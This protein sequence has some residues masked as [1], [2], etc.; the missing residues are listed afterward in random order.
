[1]L[2]YEPGRTSHN[3][4][5]SG[6]GQE[7]S[8]IWT[9]DVNGRPTGSPSIADGIAYVVTT[10]RGEVGSAGTLYAIHADTGVQRWSRELPA[11]ATGVPTVAGGVVYVGLDGGQVVGYNESGGR[12]LSIPNAAGPESVISSIAVVDDVLYIAGE[13]PGGSQLAAYNETGSQLWGYTTPEHQAR[14]PA[15]GDGAAYLAVNRSLIALSATDGTQQWNRTLAGRTM[16]STPSVAGGTVYVTTV[17]DAGT[18][19]PGDENGTLYAL[20]AANGSIRWSMPIDPYVDSRSFSPFPNVTAT[21]IPAVAGDTVYVGGEHLYAFDAS[22]GTLVSNISAPASFAPGDMNAHALGVGNAD[23]STQQGSP[24]SASGVV[25]ATLSYPTVSELPDDVA[26]F[27]GGNRLWLYDGNWFGGHHPTVVNGTLFVSSNRRVYAL[28]GPT[29]IEEKNP[30]SAALSANRSRAVVGESVVEFD[31]GNSIDSDG[32]IVEYQWDFDG[33]RGV[34]MTTTGPTATHVYTQTGTFDARVTVVDND[35]LTDTATVTITVVS[36]TTTEP[37]SGWPQFHFNAANTGYN[38]T[39]RG[40]VGPVVERWNVSFHGAQ[41]NPVTVADG[42][43]YVVENERVQARHASNGTLVWSTSLDPPGSEERFD[44]T[45]AP[46]V[47]GG[48]VYVGAYHRNTTGESHDE[49]YVLDATTGARIWSHSAHVPNW[50]GFFSDGHE[51]GAPKVVDGRLFYVGEAGDTLYAV[52][53]TAGSAH[54]ELWNRTLAGSARAPVA[55]S[56]GSVYV[57][58]T[59]ELS[60]YD[61]ASGSQRWT[62]SPVDSNIEAAPTVVDDRLYVGGGGQIAA[63]YVTNGSRVWTAGGFVT[64]DWGSAA[65]AGDLVL[66][67]QTESS[68]TDRDPNVT[69]LYVKNGTEAWSFTTNGSVYGAPAVVGRSGVGVGRTAY[70]GTVNGTLHGIDVED[71]TERWNYTLPPGEDTVRNDTTGG[72]D[73]VSAPLPIF[74]A[75]AVTDETV[76]VRAGSNSVLTRAVYAITDAAPVQSA[77]GDLVANRTTAR[78]AFDTVRFSVTNLTGATPSAYQWEFGDGATDRTTH[79]DTDVDHVYSTAGTLTVKVTALDRFDRILFTDSVTVTV[80]PAGEGDL[81]VNPSFADVNVTRVNFTVTNVTSGIDAHTYAWDFDGDGGVDETTTDDNDTDHVYSRLLGSITPSVEVS[82]SQG[83]TLFTAEAS[84]TVGDRIP[85][86]VVA[87]APAE[88]TSGTDFTV[89]A[90]NSTDNHRI[91]EFTFETDQGLSVTNSDGVATLNFSSGSIHRVN[92]SAVDPS[93]NRNETNLTIVVSEPPDLTA[94]VTAP[95]DQNLNNGS[96]HANVTVENVGDITARNVDVTLNVGSGSLY[97][98]YRVR[99]KDFTRS[100]GD[101]APGENR[102]VGIDFTDWAGQHIRAGRPRVKLTAVADPSDAISEQNE[103]NNRAETVTRVSFSDIH[104]NVYVPRGITNESRTVT[105]FFRNHGG[106]RSDNHT[107]QIDFGDGSSNVTVDIPPLE[108]YGR[109]RV[110]LKHT[111]TIPGSYTAVVNVTDDAVERG[112]VDRDT[113]RTEDYSLSIRTFDVPAE[114]ERGESFNPVVRFSRN[115][116]RP[117]NATLE[118]PE[119]LEFVSGS[120]RAVTKRVDRFGRTVWWQIRAVNES[121]PDRHRLNVTVESSGVTDNATDATEVFPARIQLTNTTSVVVLNNASGS[122]VGE[123]RT[124]TTYDHAIEITGQ[125]GA[126]GRTLSGLEYLFRYPYG[127]IEQTTSPL[128]GALGTDQYYRTNPPPNDYDQER[129]NRNIA[130][131]VSRLSSD[132]DNGQHANGAWSM[133]GNTPSGHVFYTAYALFG[134]GSVANDPVQGVRPAVRTELD[135]VDFNATPLWLADAQADDGHIPN[136]KRY[137]RDDNAMTGFTLLALDVGGPYNATAEAAADRIRENATRYLV[138]SQHADG[139]WETRSTPNGISTAIAV[140]GLQT[141]LPHIDNAT[142]EARAQA[143][144]DEGT[145]W[146]LDQQRPN[147]SWPG[148]FT[149][150]S[151]S[152]QGQVSHTTAYALMALNETGIPNTNASIARGTTYLVGVYDE[153]GSWGYTR[154]S[155]VA[156]DALQRLGT[157]GTGATQTVTVQ[158][159]NATTPDVVTKTVR[160]DSSTPQRTVELTDAEE[161]RLRAATDGTVEITVIG[162]GVGTAVI[163]V[164][165]DQLIDKDEYEANTGGG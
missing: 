62:T 159:G 140:R 83:R 82:D 165:N 81:V 94:S 110:D 88:V 133:Y 157:G 13:G 90:S 99:S 86:T 26:A 105:V 15:V 89:D 126:E 49:V 149:D 103:T 35:G 152:S 6:P 18:D 34:D 87:S 16:G 12:V 118:L 71:G 80:E 107:A 85:P 119:G 20:Y 115:D 142:L 117:V 64:N 60:A 28:A 41:T 145:V 134:T 141:A 93:G 163:A 156:I 114:A 75:P 164:Q 65:I 7:P 138:N 58:T 29:G 36:P 54:S 111:Y 74:T 5:V 108:R 161:A 68:F 32:S 102:T 122:T 123:I 150:F 151:W 10:R 76:Y 91:E 127:C 51:V 63:H 143:S 160:L 8:E 40:P 135:Q 112:N 84:L 146:L 121:T 113:A 96:V 9:F 44:V 46:T 30:P 25:Y 70:V 95:A 1:M 128:L 33:D 48:R 155:A 77:S 136:D 129:V 66:V 17:D 130:G 31:A 92:V 100:I 131:G 67:T 39:G 73:R 50:G 98:R 153:D 11:G 109:H 42:L 55:V 43:L 148:P 124:E 144:I 24:S 2:G 116:G 137:F 101:L 21:T 97:W 147:G 132:G 3:P 19:R 56:N 45:S 22:N 158:F 37:A 79:P 57:V 78:M 59:S 106:L 23:I 139:Y 72:F 125:L 104:A 47:A 61:A 52:D 154:A 38:A 14:S 4:N 120:G 53:A 162:N 69:A 27:S